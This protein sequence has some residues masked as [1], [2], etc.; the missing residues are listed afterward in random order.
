M[1]RCAAASTPIWQT[2]ARSLAVAWA[3]NALFVM[4]FLELD[5]IARYLQCE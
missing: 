5:L 4:L 1:W 2:L 3:A